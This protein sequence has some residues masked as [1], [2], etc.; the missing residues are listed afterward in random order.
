MIFVMGTT[1]FLSASATP[2]SMGSG[3]ILLMNSAWRNRR[4]GA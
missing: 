3:M 2:C 1:S 4:V